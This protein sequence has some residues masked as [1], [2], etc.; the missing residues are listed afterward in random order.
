MFHINRTSGRR[1]IFRL[2]DEQRFEEAKKHIPPEVCHRRLSTN[3]YSR[4]GDCWPMLHRV[5]KY[6]GYDLIIYLLDEGADIELKDDNKY[7][8][9]FIAV[10]YSQMKCVELLLDRGADIEARNK[11]CIREWLSYVFTFIYRE[12]GRFSISSLKI[13]KR[14][15]ANYY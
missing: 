1:K 3:C 5:V 13:N 6:G 7:T 11:V 8:P 9:L 14:K 2:I 4:Y 12:E 15:C 10:T